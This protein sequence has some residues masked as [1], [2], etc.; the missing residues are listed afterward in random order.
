MNKV[1]TM[2]MIDGC[3]LTYKFGNSIDAK[4]VVTLPG[5]N[6]CNVYVRNNFLFLSNLG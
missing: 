5:H 4:V 1:C 2:S 6:I 3:D